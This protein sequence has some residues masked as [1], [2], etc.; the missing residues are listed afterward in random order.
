MIQSTQQIEVLAKLPEYFMNKG[1]KN[2][3]EAFDGPFQYATGTGTSH[4]C[5]SD[6]STKT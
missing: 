1:Y 6:P 2:P 4:I 3:Q 5:I